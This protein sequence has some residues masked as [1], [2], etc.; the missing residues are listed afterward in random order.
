MYTASVRVHDNVRTQVSDRQTD[1]QTDTGL[2]MTAFTRR[3]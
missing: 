1:R 2:Y 3:K